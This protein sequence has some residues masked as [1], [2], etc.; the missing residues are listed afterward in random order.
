MFATGAQTRSRPRPRGVRGRGGGEPRP[1]N[2]QRA[3][4][5]DPS[6]RPSRASDHGISAANAKR[7]GGAAPGALRRPFRL[8]SDR[9]SAPPAPI[10]PYLTVTVFTA[11]VLDVPEC[12]T[13]TRILYLPFLVGAFHLSE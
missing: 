6:R 11:E 8:G 9:G 3:S 5:D 1:R 10:Q 13:R 4:G 2:G 7:A 12:V